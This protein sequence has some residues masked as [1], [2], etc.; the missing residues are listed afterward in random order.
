MSAMKNAIEKYC[1]VTNSK[2][3]GYDNGF[4]CFYNEFDG[5]RVYLQHD[6]LR[7]V[8]NFEWGKQRRKENDRERTD[9]RT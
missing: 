8:S 7:E 3:I 4:Y 1:R 6:L 9:R 5:K 2:F